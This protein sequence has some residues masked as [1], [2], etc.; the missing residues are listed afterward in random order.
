MNHEEAAHRTWQIAASIAERSTPRVD[1]TKLILF[2][3]VTRNRRFDGNASPQFQA[4][5]VRRSPRPYLFQLGIWIHANH[6]QQM[7]R[8]DGR[9]RPRDG[10]YDNLFPSSRIVVTDLD[11]S[12]FW[13]RVFKVK[14]VSCY[15]V[16]TSKVQ[17]FGGSPHEAPVNDSYSADNLTLLL[18]SIS[19]SAQSPCAPGV[20]FWKLLDAVNVGYNDGRL[21]VDKLYA[22]CLPTPA[23]AST[24]NYPYDHDGGGKLS[25]L[26]RSADGKALNTYVWYAESIG[27]LWELSHF[28][29]IGGDQSIKP[30][31]PGNYM[32]E[33]AVEDKPFYRFPFSVSE[34]KND[35]PYQ[36]AGSRYFIEGAWNE[37]GN[38]FYQRNDPKSTLRFTTWLQD[39]SGHVSKTPV[40]TEI[41]F[42]RARDSKVLGSATDSF[43]LEPRWHQADFYFHPPGD[44]NV[45]LTAADLLSEDG[46]F[47][48]RLSV[49]ERPYGDYAFTVKGG[50]IQ[51]QGKQIRENTDSMQYIVDYLS[52][53]RYSSW[54]VTRGTK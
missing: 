48:V 23:R 36:P 43:R 32:L 38:I 8:S 22:V 16:S 3:P 37:Y 31:A 51:F 15:Q 17:N 24:S 19:A 13:L 33:F 50:K 45:F 26:V 4:R 40:P 5:Y 54:W 39:K 44:K 42:I 53:G 12:L 28:K 1:Q 47:I 25:T 41:K 9:I 27:G 49:N 11:H 46:R 18:G 6:H 52:G 21:N 10:S 20:S 30:L 2:M 14:Y 35:D 29:V 7:F 34:L